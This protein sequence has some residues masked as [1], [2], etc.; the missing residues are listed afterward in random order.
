MRPTPLAAQT[1]QTPQAGRP[2]A[3]RGHDTQSPAPR[4][5]AAVRTV[6]RRGLNTPRRRSF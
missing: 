4:G 2:T 3:R 6:P 5:S 1:E